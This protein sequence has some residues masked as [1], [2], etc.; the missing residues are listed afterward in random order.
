MKKKSRKVSGG[1][2]GDEPVQLSKFMREKYS[3][4]S[5]KKIKMKVKKSKSD[6]ERERN[7]QSLLDYLNS[8]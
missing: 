1:G 6:K 4:L 8:M 3:A 5:G 7:R 2:D